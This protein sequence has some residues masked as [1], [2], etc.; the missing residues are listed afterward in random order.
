MLFVVQGLLLVFAVVRRR[1]L[2]FRFGNSVADW[3]GI[4]LLAFAIAFY[5]L[6]CVFSGL[7]WA[8]TPMFGVTAPSTVLFTLGF[9]LLAEPRTSW[10]VGIV[11]FVWTLYAG[12]VAWAL[13]MSHDYALPAAGLLALATAFIRLRR[14]T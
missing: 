10:V 7:D 11:P 6:L 9:L 12:Y 5:P 1:D 8:Q 13:P 2:V 4:A 3:G 14:G